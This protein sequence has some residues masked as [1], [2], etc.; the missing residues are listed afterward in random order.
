MDQFRPPIKDRNTEELLEIVSAPDRWNP[1]AVRQASN[2]L[3]RRNVPSEEIELA[4]QIE[5]E[6]RIQDREKKANEGYNILDF[7]FTP[8]STLAE[9]ILSWQLKSDGYL[10]KARQQKRF[11]IGLLI[12]ILGWFLY[13]YFSI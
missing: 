1:E 8:I 12:F 5:E 7:I 11:R 9:L 4:K 3:V 10:R 6:W 2:E 13:R